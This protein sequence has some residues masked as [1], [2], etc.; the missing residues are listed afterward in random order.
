MSGRLIVEAKIQP[1]P[2]ITT[3]TQT[4]AQKP[5]AIP[6]IK[7]GNIIFHGERIYSV[8]SWSPDDSIAFMRFLYCSISSVDVQEGFFGERVR[9]GV[10][11]IKTKGN[12]DNSSVMKKISRANPFAKVYVFHTIPLFSNGIYLFSS[13]P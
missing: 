6:A 7:F 4:N 2:Q 9:E 3:A 5:R 13:S 8:N 1:R 12:E 11:S 10:F